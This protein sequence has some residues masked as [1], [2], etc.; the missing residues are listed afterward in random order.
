MTLA[1]TVR[2]VVLRDGTTLRL[3][4]PGTDDSRRLFEFFARLSERSTYLRFHGFHAT[5]DA[6]VASIVEGDTFD[7]G[8]LIGTLAVEGRERVVGLATYD[9]LR[10]PALAE[11]AF[12]VDD[13]HQGRGIGTRLLEQL[14]AV[15][16]D[17]GVERFVAHVLPDNVRMLSVFSEAGFGVVRRASDG[18]IEVA[19]PIQPTSEYIARVDERDHLAVAASIRPFFTPRTVA[20]VGSSRRRGTIGGELFRNVLE[21]DFD[22]IVHPVNRTGEP[23]AGVRAFTSVEEIEGGVDLAVFAL[24]ADAV[25]EAVEAALVS[26]TRAVCVISAGFREVGP[27]GAERE[28]RL[29]ALVRSH[30]ARLIGPNCVGIFVA[31]RSLNATFAAR[32]FP[33]GSIAFS[34]QSGALGLTLLERAADAGLGFSA[35]VSIGNKA[36]V[37]SN[38][39]LEYW[40]DDETTKLVALYLESFGNPRKF[41]RIAR[42]LA[43]RKP[44]V[45]MKG[46]RSSLGARAAAS[47][48]AALAG[49]E[50]AVNAL[51]RQAG[52]VAVESLEEFVGVSDLLA[53]QALPRGRSVGILT[54]AGGLGILCADA[55]DAAKLTL[56]T[57]SNETRAAIGAA[58]APGSSLENPVDILGSA[59]I[60]T[61]EGTL[62]P[63]LA[64]SAVDAVVVLAVPTVALAAADAAA[65]IERAAARSEHAKPV[66]AVVVGR[67][68]GDDGAVA[69]RRVTHFDYPESAA[70]ALGRA[71]ERA[72]W[73][74]RPVGTVPEVDGIV[75]HRA[76]DVV[77]R[78]LAQ[79]EDA[80]LDPAAAR[81]LL[82]AFGLPLVTELVVE[83]SD[84]AV[85]GAEAVGLPAVV[86]SGVAGA[87]K[88]EHGGVALDLR[89]TDAVR[90]AAKRIGGRVIVQPMISGGVELLA[91]LVQDATFGALVG[92]GPGG[93][94]AELI[95]GT[96]FRIAPL[97]DVDA[98]EL[99]TGGK[100]GQLVGGFRNAPPASVAALADLLHRLSR[101]GDGLPEVAE[102]DLNPVFAFPD[103]CVV[104]DAR[105][106][107]RRPQRSFAVRTW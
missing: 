81:E 42:R 82:E 44:I 98:H 54:N 68:R 87:H 84:A 73:L 31:E 99:V 86:K 5:A 94:L 71:A 74:H 50:V 27:E 30:G 72:E 22:G 59:T 1:A 100:A 103:R 25:L 41:A 66:L 97:T 49:S 35:F 75:E 88:T 92:F 62:E 28:E 106:R 61:F 51:F 4:A 76:R 2:D 34:S 69:S 13:A 37:S 24:P 53:T 57:L 91:G 107:V 60:E 16:A 29:L 18:E 102:L 78:A 40:E 70:R 10:D 14:A 80:W 9:R 20:I 96:A 93:T 15:A 38:D 104:V 65:A 48:T 23:V 55:F 33:S 90:A 67:E 32:S 85:T 45:A 17:E 19:F 101:I 6:V 8:A 79:A 52:V 46:G 21:G 105:V 12:S 7:R 26:G 43:R 77:E 39:L 89:T 56:A 64:D 83:S 63:L 47:H 58:V 11:V 3:R 95:G 36:D